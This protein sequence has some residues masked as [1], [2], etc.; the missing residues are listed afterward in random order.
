M[1]SVNGA[2]RQEPEIAV[3]KQR[4]L[5]EIRRSIFV[6]RIDCGGMQRL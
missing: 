6:Y 1:T 4:L 5:K 2:I 3:L